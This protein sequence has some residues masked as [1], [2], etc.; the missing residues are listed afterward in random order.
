MK[1]QTISLILLSFLAF[2]ACTPKEEAQ[3]EFDFT[4]TCWFDGYEFFVGQAD[5][6]RPGTFIFEGGNLHE[7]G[8]NF[9]LQRIAVDT[10]VIVPAYELD[11]DYV[12]V[13]VV[14][15]TATRELIGDRMAIICHRPDDPECDT[16]W[17]FDPGTKEPIQAYEDLL[18]AKR[19]SDLSGTYYDAKKK[20][21]YT[22]SD[23]TLIRTKDNGDTDTNSFSIFYAFD[24]PSH[25]LIISEKEQFWYERTPQGLDLFHVKYWK[26][27]DDYTREAR[28]A[29]LTRQ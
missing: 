8:A 17:M 18:I 6:T 12:S 27:E 24:M 21:T 13:G 16:L 5:T 10:F 7:G 14:G 4:N 11:I 23:T 20:I 1:K 26:S 3:T 25:V 22:F 9:A 2:A 29:V 15:D 19:L 28:F